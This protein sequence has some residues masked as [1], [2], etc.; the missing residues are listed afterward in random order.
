MFLITFGQVNILVSEDPLKKNMRV[1]PYQCSLR[2]DT[3][4]KVFLVSG[5]ITKRGGGAKTP[6]TI[7]K[8]TLFSMI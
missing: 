6:L 1:W 2:E 8:I 7:K 4:K 3:H 5:R